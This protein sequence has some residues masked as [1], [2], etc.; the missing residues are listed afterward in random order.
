MSVNNVYGWFGRGGVRV[1]DWLLHF[2]TNLPGRN[3]MRDPEFAIG[4]VPQLFIWVRNRDGGLRGF[5]VED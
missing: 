3:R 4:P 5:R 2:W 1:A